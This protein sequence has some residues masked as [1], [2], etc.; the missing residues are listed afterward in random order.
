MWNEFGYFNISLFFYWKNKIY[1]NG[2][3]RFMVVKG[4]CEKIFEVEIWR[5][6]YEDGIYGSILYVWVYIRIKGI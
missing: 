3:I 5:W 2:R 1:K 6:E 4:F